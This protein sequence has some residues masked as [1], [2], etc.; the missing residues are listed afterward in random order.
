MADYSPA[1][2]AHIEALYRQFVDRCVQRMGTDFLATV[3]TATVARDMD[4]VRRIIGD[5]QINYLGFSYGTEIGGAYVDQ[6]EEHVRAMVLDGAVDP[7]IGPIDK[8]I[9]QMAAFQLAFDDYAADCAGY[10]DCPLG[11]EPAQWV[12]RYHQLVNPLV[13]RPAH[14]S[15]P[16]GLG[17]ADAITGSV[18]ALYT[19]VFWKYL[20]SGLLGLQHG[21]DAGDLLLLADEYQGRRTDGTYA[22]LQDAFNAVRCMDAPSPTDPAVWAAADKRIREV[23]PFIAYG[24]FTGYAPRDICSFWPVPP[25][26]YPAAATPVAPGKVVVVS[27]THDPATPY[28]A[29]VDLARQLGAPLITYE[30]TQHTAVFN[31]IECVDTAIVNYFVDGVVPGNLRC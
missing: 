16:R 25:T 5:D 23:A 26:S 27:T 12:N 30:G 11:Q 14:T 28:Q 24:D 7:S 17:Y 13:S 9:R 8:N 15:D 22:N 2:V 20:T 1:G 4:T 6:F 19:Q 21:D 18:N 29:G 31:G 10:R 3:G